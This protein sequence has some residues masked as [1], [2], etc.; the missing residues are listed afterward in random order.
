VSTTSYTPQQQRRGEFYLL[1]LTMIWGTS[2]ILIRNTLHGVGPFTLLA[3]RFIIGFLVLFI[4]FNRRMRRITRADVTAGLL[5]GCLFFAGNALQTS[6][7]QYTSASVSGFITALSVVMVPPVA[8]VILRQRVTRGAVLGIALATIGLALLS[9]KDGLSLGYGDLLT[10]GCAVVFAFHIV[11]TSKYAARTEP[12]VMVAVQFALA[13][14]AALAVAGTTETIG[15]LSNEV[16]LAALYLGLFPTALCFVLQVYGQRRTSATRAALIYTAEPVFA[17][18]F[19]YLVAGEM[20]GPRGLVGC[21]L[22]LAG[23]LAA[24]LA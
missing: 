7:L 18:L 8:L 17:A 4:L 23:M 5:L 12:T 10:L 13:A 19:A 24:E 1:F 3:M 2:F 15:P 22:I 6:G 21:V 20:L 14:L 9:L 11:Y 16:W